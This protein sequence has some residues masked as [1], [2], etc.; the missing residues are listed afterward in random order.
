M[1]LYDSKP[2]RLLISSSLG[3][4]VPWWLRFPARSFNQIHN[5][6]IILPRRF[7]HTDLAGDVGGIIT[8]VISFEDFGGFFFICRCSQFGMGQSAVTG[9]G[10]AAKR[11]WDNGILGT[12]FGDGM[13][14]RVEVEFTGGAVGMQDDFLV[15]G[16]DFEFRQ[17]MVV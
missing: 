7:F 10:A 15:Y 3:V 8:V 1:K 2:Q 13:H 17:N 4:F 5:G 6:H 9:E 11:K 16:I 12:L 14:F